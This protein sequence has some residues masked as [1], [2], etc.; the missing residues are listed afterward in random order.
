M[1]ILTLMQLWKSRKNLFLSYLSRC[2]LHLENYSI[3]FHWI[4][5]LQSVTIALSMLEMLVSFKHKGIY[6]KASFIY[7]STIFFVHGITLLNLILRDFSGICAPCSP[8]GAT[9][10][11]R[12]PTALISIYGVQQLYHPLQ[13]CDRNSMALGVMLD[14]SISNRILRSFWCPLSET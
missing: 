12:T 6:D 11:M 10:L 1:G 13:W 4:S 2:C 9:Y 5:S 3:F 7:Y 8:I 14:T